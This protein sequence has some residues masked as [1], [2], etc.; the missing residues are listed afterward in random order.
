MTE[1][2]PLGNQIP[3][4]LLSSSWSFDTTFAWLFTFISLSPTLHNHLLILSF[5]LSYLFSWLLS[6]LTHHS[7]FTLLH[8]LSFF[9][10]A[11]LFLWHHT[12]KGDWL[13]TRM[14]EDNLPWPTWKQ[15]ECL[16]DHLVAPGPPPRWEQAYQEQEQVPLLSSGPAFGR[17]PLV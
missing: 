17:L 4:P 1:E 5:S 2:A 10:C 16:P 6:Y 14:M 8:S 13:S 3:Q 15:S 12:G 7:M 11:G 9:K